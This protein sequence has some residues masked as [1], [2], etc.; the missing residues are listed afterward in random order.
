[1][2]LL[3]AIVPA[4][5]SAYDYSLWEL[6]LATLMLDL[7]LYPMLRY[8]GGR[9]EGF[10]ILQVLCLAFGIQ[11]A[12]PIFTQEPG[13]S[14]A[15]GFRYL[16]T[17]DIVAAQG[18]AIIGVGAL[19][20]TYFSLR[21]GRALEPLPI[22]K[23]PLN[24]RKA[25]V[26][27]VVVFCFSLLLPRFQSALSEETLLQFS[28][29]FSLLE[30]QLMVAI[31]ILTWLVFTNRGKRWHQIMLYIIVVVSALRGFSTTMLESMMIPLS[32]F[33]IA[34]W[35]YTRRLPI[36]TLVLV[37]MLFLFL[38]P[39]KRDI[40]VSIVKSGDAALEVSTVDR[41]ADWVYQA[42]SYWGEVVKGQ[43]DLVESTSDASSRTD[44]IHTFAHIYSLTPTRVP[45]QY[46]GTYSHLGVAWI[47]RAVWPEK[48]QANAANNFYAIAYEVSSEEGVKTSSF[49]AT[50]L[51]E[52]YM[53]FGPAGAVFVMI[54]LGA[55]LAGFERSFALKAS[56]TGGQAIF[57]ATFVYFLNGIGSS[58]E[59]MFGGLIQNLI[60][61]TILLW[62][63]REKS[64]AP[65]PAT[66]EIVQPSYPSL[67]A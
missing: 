67:P 36:V 62:W 40:R 9:E 57:L 34:K 44:L 50:L 11:Y 32:I 63:A 54:L 42:L 5:L 31:G 55:V 19:Q 47:P 59:L 66:A 4:A 18:L 41:A 2:L 7:C 17:A 60:A 24:P 6:I 28:A 49:G 33:F 1:M 14:T 37:A 15:F 29:L 23:L 58:A 16:D 51:G 45:Y 26:F 13:L 8:F 35:Y 12:L 21:H 64:V 22:V 53:N 25:E 43:R 65:A 10:P 3:T 61:C 48:P 39:V 56:G 20:Y 27:C 52:G 46:G 38:S 30:N